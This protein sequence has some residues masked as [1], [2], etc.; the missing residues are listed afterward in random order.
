M[1]HSQKVLKI[2]SKT[3]EILAH[4]LNRNTS[5]ISQAAVGACWG[6]WEEMFLF[7]YTRPMI[8]MSSAVVPALHLHTR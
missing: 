4:Y 1:K 7:N 3:D 8:G 2:V 6:G 5:R